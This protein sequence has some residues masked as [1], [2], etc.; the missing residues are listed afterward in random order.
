MVQLLVLLSCCDDVV[1]RWPRVR[2]VGRGGGGRAAVSVPRWQPLAAQLLVL[3]P[4]LFGGLAKLNPDWLLRHEPVRSWAPEM[5]EKLDAALGGWLDRV[6]P[7]VDVV[8]PFAAAVCWPARRVD[9]QPQQP[10]M[11]SAASHSAYIGWSYHTRLAAAVP[12]VRGART[13][14]PRTVCT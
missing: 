2:G 4:Y 13:G 7:A 6:L 1:L 11:H 12:H 14:L 9:R 5:L 3:T 10:L 8:P